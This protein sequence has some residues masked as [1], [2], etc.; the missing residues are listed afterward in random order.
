MCSHPILSPSGGGL[1]LTG[2]S[3]RAHFGSIDACLFKSHAYLSFADLF[4]RI[5]PSL[6]RFLYFRRLF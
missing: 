1:L 6:F 3:S 4:D 2:I 5:M